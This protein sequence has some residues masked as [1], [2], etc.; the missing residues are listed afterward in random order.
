MQAFVRALS[1][2]AILC[3]SIAE[4]FVQSTTVLA[5]VVQQSPRQNNYTTKTEQPRSETP[6]RGTN[7][8]K[9]TLMGVIKYGERGTFSDGSTVEPDGTIT[10][11]DGFKFQIIIR[12]RAMVGT[13][14]FNPNGEKLK[15]GETLRLRNGKVVTQISH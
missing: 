6:L 4:S 13:Q 15:P 11:P 3:I 9:M 14:F 10:T 2:A 12:N 8:G 7:R 1:V 5:E